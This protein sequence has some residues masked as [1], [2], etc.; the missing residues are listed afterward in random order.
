MRSRLGGDS[1][2]NIFLS[3]VI[4]RQTDILVASFLTS[5][6]LFL[7]SVNVTISGL[8]LESASVDFQ[9]VGSLRH[10]DYYYVMFSDIFTS[11][12]YNVNSLEFNIPE[13]KTNDIFSYNCA[14][15]SICQKSTNTHTDSSDVFDLSTITGGSQV[16]VV[17]GL[18]LTASSYVEKVRFNSEISISIGLNS[19]NR[20]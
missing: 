6:D 15:G 5:P 13:S 14:V 19:S 11:S 9:I 8:W 1:L 12:L 10:F 16:F 4:L 2:F 20:T 18:V 17:Q 3:P 7:T